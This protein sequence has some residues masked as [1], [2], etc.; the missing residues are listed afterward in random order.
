MTNDL[1]AGTTFAGDSITHLSVIADR[2]DA[3]ASHGVTLKKADADEL[4]R[5]RANGGFVPVNPD[6]L[7]YQGIGDFYAAVNSSKLDYG[8][9]TEWMTAHLAAWLRR[10]TA[11]GE[12]E[13]LSEQLV[14]RADK[15]WGEARPAVLELPA[16]FMTLVGEPDRLRFL[17]G[18]NGV[19][20]MTAYARVG[21]IVSAHGELFALRDA[22]TRRSGPGAYSVDGLWAAMQPAEVVA[23]PVAATE[24]TDVDAEGVRA[25]ATLLANAQAAAQIGA[26]HQAAIRAV[27]T[28]GDFAA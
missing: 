18:P 15:V 8:A 23:E 11:S 26:N 21:E 17:T 1:F 6:P 7:E 24:S 28:V 25:A 10:F 12:N 20:T 22:I 27:M 4:A 16:E 9:R 19:A 14:T 13:R 5:L 2:I 3:L